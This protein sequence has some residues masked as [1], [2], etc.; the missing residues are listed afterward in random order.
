MAREKGDNSCCH[1]YLTS[2][3]KYLQGHDLPPVA[4]G[5]MVSRVRKGLARCQ[6]DM[7]LRPQRLP[8]PAP[9]ALAILELA[10]RLQL[11]V[12]FQWPDPELNLLRTAVA[13][14]TAYMFFNRRACVACA[15]RGD[16][17]VDISFVTLLLRQ[18][19]G[20]KTLG[21]GR[22][23]GRSR[24]TRL[25]ASPRSCELSSRDCARWKGASPYGPLKIQR[26]GPRTPSPDG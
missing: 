3:N 18:E 7:A 12:Q 4:L 16:I 19:N 8:V 15:L 22:I 1:P 9:V 13:T 20:K 26:F 25:S 5:I 2:I 11:S 10:E 21:V 24:T 14:I 17:V 23:S 6:E